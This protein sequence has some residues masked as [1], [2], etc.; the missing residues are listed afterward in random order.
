MLLVLLDTLVEFDAF[1]AVKFQTLSVNVYAQYQLSFSA[2]GAA[3]LSLFA[4]ALCLLA[5]FGEA[6]V[7]GGANY[8]RI[9]HG[10][11]RGVA[12]YEL[13]SWMPAVLAGLGLLV[14]VSVGIPLG[15]LAHWFASGTST[16]G[17]PA[18]AGGLWPA[19][20]T[21]VL[22]GVAAAL[23]ALVLALPVE[24]LAGRSSGRIAARS[25]SPPRRRTR[26]C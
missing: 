10:A 8:T 19:T 20:V 22:L 15:L 24:I 11:P 6:R 12:R 13:G 23:T 2:A 21:S 1:V 18:G 14:A 4:T 5:L 25:R 17:A 16:V 9:S 3:A 26:R 7:R